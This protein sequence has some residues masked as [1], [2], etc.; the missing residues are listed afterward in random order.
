MFLFVVWNVTCKSSFEYYSSWERKKFFVQDLSGDSWESFFFI[1]AVFVLVVPSSSFS[2][3]I[4]QL[5]RSSVLWLTLCSLVQ[6]WKQA[7]L[8]SAHTK[9]NVFIP[10][11][12]IFQLL[13]RPGPSGSFRVHCL[14]GSTLIIA[15]LAFLFLFSLT[16]SVTGKSHYK[17]FILIYLKFFWT[18]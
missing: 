2:E 10:I 13:L 15:S 18:G 1:M 9:I 3:G 17:R 14:I 16:L 11:P 7:S 12:F 8:F 6:F 4:L 5:F